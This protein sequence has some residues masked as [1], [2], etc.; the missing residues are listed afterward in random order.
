MKRL[1]FSPGFTLLE[2]IIVV[3]IVGI[4]G[5]VGIYSLNVTRAM[6]RDAKRVSDVS[7]IRAALTQFWLQSATYPVSDPVDLG[8]PGANADKLGDTGFVAANTVTTKQFLQAVPTGPNAGEYYRY[9]GS[10]TGY[11]LRFTTER[12][13]AYGAAGIWYAHSTGVDH[14]DAE[15]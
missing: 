5:A 1:R 11:S 3:L 10:A 9:H 13:T 8:R 12:A 15:E 7:V 2:I 14:Q 4:L 6:N